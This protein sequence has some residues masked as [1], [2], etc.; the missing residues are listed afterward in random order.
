[1]VKSW[2][3]V[4]ACSG[5]LSV[6]LGAFGAH[7]L[8]GKISESLF[9]AF[10]TAI[11]YQMFHTLALLGVVVLMSQLESVPKGLSTACFLWLVGIV[12]FSGSL[13]GLALGG[14]SWLGPVTPFGGL[15]LM[16]GWVSILVGSLQLKL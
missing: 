15:L 3:I 7:G 4:I 1:M 11:H 10:Q 2:L 12:F 16:A 14:P 6:A 5:F 9:S 8:K 13:Y